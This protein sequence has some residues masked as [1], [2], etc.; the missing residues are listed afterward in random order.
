MFLFND[1]LDNVPLE[2]TSL[3]G[4]GYLNQQ[5]QQYYSNNIDNIFINNVNNGF[6]CKLYLTK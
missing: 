6:I 4:K 2:S 1:N 5:Y 3:R